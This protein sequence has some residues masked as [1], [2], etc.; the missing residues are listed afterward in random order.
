MVLGFTDLIFTTAGLNSHQILRSVKVFELFYAVGLFHCFAFEWSCTNSFHFFFR[1][2]F[3]C[4]FIIFVSFFFFFFLLEMNQ[5]PCGTR[6]VM[7]G[8][9]LCEFCMPITIP[10][11]CHSVKLR[12]TNHFLIRI[13]YIL[14]SYI[15]LF[16]FYFFYTFGMFFM[17]F[18]EHFFADFQSFLMVVM[19]SL[20]SMWIS[21]LFIFRIG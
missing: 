17:W 4:Y 5:L 6:W 10:L 11:K 19:K 2:S 12:G 18:C 7:P 1:F 8:M 3:P 15:F 9:A 20:F 16:F 21:N 14:L 13:L